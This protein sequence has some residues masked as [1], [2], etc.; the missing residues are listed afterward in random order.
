V[1]TLDEEGFDDA[2]SDDL[3][4]SWARHFLDAVDAWQADGFAGVAKRYLRHLDHGKGGVPEIDDGG[5]LLIRWPGQQPP[6]RRLLKDSLAAPTWL[7]PI[8]GAPRV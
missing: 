8:S 7:D 1:T 2:G 6:D 5:N 4:A 3:I